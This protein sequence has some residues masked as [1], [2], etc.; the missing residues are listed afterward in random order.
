MSLSDTSTLFSNTFRDSDSSTSLG[1]LCHCLTTLSDEKFSLISSLNLSWQ[2]KAMNSL[3][4]SF[5]EEEANLHLTTT[6]YFYHCL[7][8]GHCSPDWE[9]LGMYWGTGGGWS[10]LA[11]GSTI[12]KWKLLFAVQNRAM[13]SASSHRNAASSLGEVP[14]HLSVLRSPWEDCSWS[15]HCRETEPLAGSFSQQLSFLP[16]AL[17][18]SSSQCAWY[19]PWGLETSDGVGVEL[20]DDRQV[21]WWTKHSMQSGFWHSSWAKLAWNFPL[22]CFVFLKENVISVQSKTSRGERSVSLFIF[23]KTWLEYFES[24]ASIS[25]EMIT[26][27]L[28]SPTVGS[29]WNHFVLNNI[30]MNTFVSSGTGLVPSLC[31]EK[32]LSNSACMKY[33]PGISWALLHSPC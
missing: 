26:L 19:V 17:T 13:P 15:Y 7:A 20:E 31:R 3:S 1:S 27:G 6:S 30:A 24:N 2:L 25:V 11:A 29:L 10:E 14:C 18:S 28:H 8:S 33:R 21:L 32:C 22:Q 23:R 5:L 9:A 16:Q 12:A 4:I